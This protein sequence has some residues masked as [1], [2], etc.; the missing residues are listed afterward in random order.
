MAV[1]R[2]A[3]TA[4]HVVG[5]GGPALPSGG[6]HRL[7]MRMRIINVGFRLLTGKNALPA[8]IVLSVLA[9]LGDAITTAEAAFTLFYVIP[10][11]IVTWFRGLRV[12]VAI[13]AL[14]V[15]SS[16]GVDIL[17][18]PRPS[19]WIFTLW[20][21]LAESLLFLAFAYTIS[22]LRRRV[23]A[24][25]ALR[26]AALD[27]LRHAERL[28]TVGKLASGLAHELGTPLNVISGRADLISQGRVDL[29]G[30]KKSAIIIAAQAERM[31]NLV[32]NILAFARRAGA[33][34][35]SE[36]VFALCQE[37]TQLLAPLAKQK[38]IEIAVRGDS[39]HAPVNR[40]EFQQVLSNL[41]ANA[42]H[43]MADGGTITVSIEVMRA[44]L[45]EN[46]DATE[47]SYVVL[48]VRDEGMGIAPTVLPYIF[49]P[50][51]TTK[52]V[53]EGTG[54]GLSI[55]FGIVRDHGGSIRVESA[56]GDGT[57]FVLYLP[58]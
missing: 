51:F 46:G 19:S 5:T 11:V 32:R 40:S 25:T 14:C 17:F 18:G 6:S 29:D 35:S 48:R 24:E 13:I 57:T 7:P 33:E 8:A 42:V 1:I 47:R 41:I 53:G 22:L 31:E 3:S 43:A 2:R 21:A 12:A 15:A 27:Q 56:L 37:T 10:V 44:T 20:N 30:A 28:N 4:R 55:V 49:D 58:Q 45:E 39:A 34:T 16:A 38:N 23:D 36:D 9:G 50:F 54:L 52:E 26:R